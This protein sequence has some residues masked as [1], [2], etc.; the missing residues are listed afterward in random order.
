MLGILEDQSDMLSQIFF[1]EILIGDI[2]AVIIY[3][4]RSRQHKSVQVLDKR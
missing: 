3:I 2:P 4:S 1:I